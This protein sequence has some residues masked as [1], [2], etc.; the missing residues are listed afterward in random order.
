MAS[1]S[2][3]SSFASSFAFALTVVEAAEQGPGPGS[4]VG[5]HSR[6]LFL[7]RTVGT[8]SVVS[9]TY[10]VR[11]ASTAVTPATLRHSSG[12]KLLTLEQITY[13]VF[14]TIVALKTV[15]KDFI[16]PICYILF[17]N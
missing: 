4:A 3:F 12:Y 13:D 17:E 7:G 6:L 8:V 5:S 9:Y 15:T 14:K 2:R 10:T 11:A 16:K 1:S